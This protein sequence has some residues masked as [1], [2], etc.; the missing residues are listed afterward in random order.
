[1]NL[2]SELFLAP[3]TRCGMYGHVVVDHEI[4]GR[5]CARCG[6]FDPSWRLVEDGSWR[7]QPRECKQ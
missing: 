3:E 4:L 7:P 5:A 2:D 6:R 1:M